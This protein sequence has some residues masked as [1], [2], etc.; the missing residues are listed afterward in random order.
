MT[1]DDLAKVVKLLQDEGRGNYGVVYGG[2]VIIEKWGMVQLP[3]G[4]Y[5]LQL[6]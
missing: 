5:A 4:R 1:I 3:D 2:G 6:R